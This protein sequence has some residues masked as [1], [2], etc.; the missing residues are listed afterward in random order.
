MS[1]TF[2]QALSG[3]DAAAQALDV[4][5]NNISNANTTGFKR[6][7]V[8]FADV[9]ANSISSSSNNPVGLGVGVESVG[10][11]FAQGG[12]TNTGNNLDVG[13]SGD[14]FFVVRDT[15]VREDVYTRAGQFS[16]DNEGYLT[17]AGGQ[18]VLGFKAD[19]DGL[20]T[21]DAGQALDEL[22]IDVENLP[23]QK[24]TQ[25]DV[26]FNLDA[27]SELIPA[28]TAFD[29]TNANTYNNT[30]TLTVFDA[31][32]GAHTLTLYFK[33]IETGQ[34][35]TSASNGGSRWEVYT[36][37]DDGIQGYLNSETAVSEPKLLLEFDGTGTMTGWSVN[38]KSGGSYAAI[39]GN[40]DGADTDTLPDPITSG[41]TPTR[42]TVYQVKQE[43]SQ[44]LPIIDL[45]FTLPTFA[46]DP[47]TG[48]SSAATNP[49]S[50]QLTLGDKEF[51]T[52]QYVDN[53]APQFLEQNGN[54]SGALSGFSLDDE[55]KLVVRY[56]NGI[57]AVKG[58]LALA[59]FRAPDQLR[60][61][62]GNLFIPTPESGAARRLPPGFVTENGRLGSVKP[63]TLE[64]SNVDLTQELVRLIISQRLYQANA[65]TIQVQ[66]E[67]AQAILTVV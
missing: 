20:I 39:T 10:R 40:A 15:R 29:H 32:G 60:S 46:S 55:G 23:S 24:T 26:R 49:F 59:N 61:V 2:S 31:V 50:F 14:G 22:R 19:E 13:I 58:Q 18:R 37:L 4:A 52:T 12:L 28:T 54:S 3:L 43:N 1:F 44:S 63:G 45:K 33:R 17:T 9:Y 25:V 11:I 67:A 66:S 21:A 8:S 53:F 27:D 6:S 51:L 62:S 38:S 65:K 5:G 64:E 42:G 34:I 47:P 35:L 36:R 30:N 56:D 7:R 57:T 48:T 41:G 16:V